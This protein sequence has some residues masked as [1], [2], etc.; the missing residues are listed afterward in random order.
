MSAEKMFNEA[1]EL[2][3]WMISRPSF[4]R[5]EAE[6]A[7]FLHDFLTGKG[8]DVHRSGNNMWMFNRHFDPGKPTILLNSHIDTVKPAAGYLRGPFVPVV[9]GDKLY[10]LGS[11][12]AGASVVSLIETFIYFYD[13][14]NLK[15][16]LCLALTAEEECSGTGGIESILP[17]IDNVAFAVVGE[18][19]GMNM[20]IAEKGL[21]VVDC[22]SHG[23]A[24]HAAR[25]EG[26][27][28]IYKALK[29]IEWFRDYKF[30]KVSDTLGETVMS[31]TMIN[32]GSQHNV[33]P[34]ECR[35]TADVRLTEQYTHEEVL[36][37]IRRNTDCE[38]TPR[39]KRLKPS[40]IPADHPFVQAG[41][42]AGSTVFG[43][44][45]MSDQALIP[46]P[47]L[48]MGPGD[49]R[50]SHTADEYILLP[51]I[52]EGIKLYIEIFEKI[53]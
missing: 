25:G 47:S 36:E 21:M 45:T 11:T 10:G 22:V 41:L 9:E 46:Y 6:V 27:N 39:S 32:A 34:A 13:R 23:I 40:S 3:K 4:S 42:A 14:E 26:E 38:V 2:L 35:F 8:M 50:R 12:D 19:T 15:Y 20:A 1:V 17:E 7:A 28:A 48:K 29:D 16:N 51:E 30:P 52:A 18:P 53:L 24:G 43:S 5:E 44:P 37:I 31:V 49:S 33:I